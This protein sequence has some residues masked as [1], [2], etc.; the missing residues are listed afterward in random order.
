MDNM[1]TYYNE[2]DGHYS[3]HGHFFVDKTTKKQYLPFWM[4]KHGELIIKLIQ[5]EDEDNVDDSYFGESI[6][7]RTHWGR[8]KFVEKNSY[9]I[10]KHMVIEYDETDGMKRNP[11]VEKK[12]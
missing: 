12:V 9:D 8:F 3:T 11:I 7:S 5:V 6:D 2:N 4:M 1:I 10:L